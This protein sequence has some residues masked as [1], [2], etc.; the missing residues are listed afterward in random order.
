MLD[1]VVEGGGGYVRR[2]MDEEEDLCKTVLL[3]KHP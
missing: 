2:V 3:M 1:M